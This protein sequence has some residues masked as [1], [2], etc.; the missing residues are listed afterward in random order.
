MYEKKNKLSQ[1]ASIL[2]VISVRLSDDVYRNINEKCAIFL[3]GCFL[4]GV[5]GN[6]KYDL[7]RGYWTL[8]LL[9]RVCSANSTTRIVFSSASVCNYY[10]F[11]N[12]FYS[13]ILARKSFI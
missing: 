2:D 3:Y 13:T 8:P 5:L 6:I 12:D 1:P 7:L 4:M 10:S 11:L 9:S